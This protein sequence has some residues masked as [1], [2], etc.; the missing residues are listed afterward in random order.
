MYQPWFAA[1]CIMLEDDALSLT[2]P[3]PE[4]C[5]WQIVRELFGVGGA[6]IEVHFSVAMRPDPSSTGQRTYP[7]PLT[8]ICLFQFL[9][10]SSVTTTVGARRLMEACTR[11]CRDRLSHIFIFFSGFHFGVLVPPEISKILFGNMCIL[12]FQP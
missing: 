1:R 2:Q 5:Y 11:T 9:R 3:P 7:F 4:S 6:L 8:A 10:H 12:E